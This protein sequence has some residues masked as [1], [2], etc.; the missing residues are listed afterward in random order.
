MEYK[1]KRLLIKEFIP[2]YIPGM[3]K[4]WGQ[5]NEVGKYLVGFKKD[6]TLD[7]FTEFIM[8]NSNTGDNKF[9]VQEKDN[10]EIIGYLDLYREDFRSKTVTLVIEKDKWDKG[11]G[12]EVLSK[13]SEVERADG[14]GSLYATCDSHNERAFK[15]LEDTKFEDI[16]SIPNERKDINGVVGDEILFE[17]EMIRVHYDTN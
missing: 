12:K 9:V 10:K 14:L 11:Y 6:F 17:L 1:T 13:V 8:S 16:D 4:S 15:V 2:E 7:E 5:D 3:Y